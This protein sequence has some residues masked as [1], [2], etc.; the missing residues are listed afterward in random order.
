ME[1]RANGQVGLVTGVRGNLGVAD[2]AFFSFMGRSRAAGDA[3]GCVHFASWLANGKTVNGMNA[4]ILGA[5]ESAGT[6]I[7]DGFA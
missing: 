3:A 5:D 7:Q 4:R 6:P 1:N 2:I